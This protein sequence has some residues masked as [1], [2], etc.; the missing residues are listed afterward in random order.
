[1]YRAL[2]QSA[3]II[4]T[5]FRRIA[6]FDSPY[7]N[8]IGIFRRTL[9]SMWVVYHRTIHSIQFVSFLTHDS[10]LRSQGRATELRLIQVCCS[11]ESSWYHYTVH[12]YTVFR[13]DRMSFFVACSRNPFLRAVAHSRSYSVFAYYLFGFSC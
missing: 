1:M 3:H 13:R 8:S 7:S 12:R 6:V 5:S 4:Y 11:S 2:D 9:T 10:V